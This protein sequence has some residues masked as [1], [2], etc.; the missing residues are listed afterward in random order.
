MI[1]ACAKHV[2]LNT[3][4]EETFEKESIANFPNLEYLRESSIP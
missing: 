1:I 4:R 3:L 2:E